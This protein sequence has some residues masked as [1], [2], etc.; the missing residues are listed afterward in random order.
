MNGSPTAMHIDAVDAFARTLYLRTKQIPP[1]TFDDA[2]VAVRQMHI[3]LRHLR[4]EARDAKSV[5]NRPDS[6]VYT[7]QL[8]PIVEDCEFA[9][10]QLETV[11]G[12]Y[13]NA[14]GPPDVAALIDRI[15]SVTAKIAQEEMNVAFFLDTV[16][17]H[18]KS[19]TDESPPLPD[20]ATL[21]EI[22]EEI[23][24]MASRV[25][26]RHAGAPDNDSEAIWREF[27]AELL[28][29][30][31]T[32]D[33]LDAHKS[34]IRA[35]I[36]KLGSAWNRNCGANP[37]YQTVAEFE[38]NTAPQVVRSPTHVPVVPP[39]IPII[40]PKETQRSPVS[41]KAIPSIKD[42]GHLS[43]KL[44]A[45]VLPS[46]YSFNAPVD[47]ELEKRADLSMTLISTKDLVAM[48]SINNGMSA[49]N[50]N[51][52][53]PQ[54]QHSHLAP[55]KPDGL[56][57]SPTSQ[58]LGS[59]PRYYSTNPSVAS[60][61][62]QNYRNTSPNRPMRLAPDRYGRE[63]PLDAEWTKVRRT[64]IS[65]EALDR[66]GVRYEA[67]PDYVAILGRLSRDEIAEFARQSAEGRSAPVLSVPP[68][69]AA[70]AQSAMRTPG[71]AS[72]DPQYAGIS[73]RSRYLDDPP[74]D[75]SLIQIIGH[76]M[77]NT[78]DN[79]EAP[80]WFQGIG[81]GLKKPRWMRRD[82]D[83]SSNSQQPR[84]DIRSWFGG[85]GNGGAG[86]SGRIRL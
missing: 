11:L 54:A 84:S 51:S 15:A 52:G 4:E 38:A 53:S 65:P 45:T 81:E 64:L 6:A 74:E 85:S 23:D 57:H 34:A 12:R 21:D 76:R 1:P 9:L 2:A 14:S 33:E 56:S 41:A 44:S 20:H 31:F 22:T 80:K 79:I 40:P 32:S 77:K 29:E 68:R 19:T 58:M 78:M 71:R 82:G 5:L 35:Y 26:T 73:T 37:T 36:R 66:A 50:L 39:K 13:D 55:N 63:I 17:V 7:R 42:D 10:K 86:G 59:S 28:K 46:Q 69:E 43:D 8:Q 47:M 83:T 61:T 3:S 70:S 62:Q 25:F 27:R 67:R 48:D 18:P 72:A 49:M 60:T 75:D 30:A 16:Q 24:V